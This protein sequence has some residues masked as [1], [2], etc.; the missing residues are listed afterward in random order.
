MDLVVKSLNP[1]KGEPTH[2][3]CKS[4]Q[5]SFFKSYHNSQ[6]LH[7]TQYRIVDFFP[8][9][10]AYVNALSQLDAE[11]SQGLRMIYYMARAGPCALRK[12]LENEISSQ[13]HLKLIENESFSLRFVNVQFISFTV[14]RLAK[15]NAGR[16]IFNCY[17]LRA[18]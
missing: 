3:V 4:L 9:L 13:G 18:K 7:L 6:L 10:I 1:S 15:R 8:V 17:Y 16:Q 2:P 14:I 5:N 12:V 11:I